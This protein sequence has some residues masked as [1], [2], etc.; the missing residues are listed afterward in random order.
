[1]MNS[2]SIQEL[3]IRSPKRYKVALAIAKGLNQGKQMKEIFAALGI[4]ANTGY[5]IKNQLREEIAEMRQLQADEGKETSRKLLAKKLLDDATPE[6]AQGLI[7]LMK[8]EETPK[9]ERRQAC[10]DI[11]D[12][13]GIRET[14][15]T[16][17]DIGKKMQTIIAA[18]FYPQ[19]K[20]MPVIDGNGKPIVD[21]ESSQEI[22]NE[23]EGM[24]NG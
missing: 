9:R 6:A 22:P 15:P 13:S 14:T 23:G 2:R 18:I 8:D 3:A 5:S 19:N 17:P 10:K 11:L 12:I 16:P 7:D 20:E 1:M 24:E 4:N 21:L